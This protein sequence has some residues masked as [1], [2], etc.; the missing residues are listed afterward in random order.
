MPA[1]EPLYKIEWAWVGDTATPYITGQMADAPLPARQVKARCEELNRL[2][3]QFRHWPT[4]ASP[5]PRK[6]KKA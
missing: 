1:A 2:Y 4:L 3:P 5:T 6:E